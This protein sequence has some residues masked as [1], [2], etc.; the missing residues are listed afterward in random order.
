[1]R[2]GDLEVLIITSRKGS[3]WVLPKGIV[4]PGMTAA[5]S[6]AKEAMEEAGVEGRIVAQSLG[7][8][9]YRKWGGT[10]EVEVFPMEVTTQRKKWPEST[11]RRREWVSLEEAAKRLDPDQLRKLL[12]RLPDALEEDAG[13]G[14]A[15]SAL[16]KPP[17]VVYLLRHAKSSWEDPLLADVDRPLAPRGRRACETM[18]RYMRFADVRPDVVLCSPSVRTR[19]TIE[20]LLPEL[21]GEVPVAYEEALYH[22]GADDLMDRLRRVPDKFNSVLIVGHNPALQALA[23]SLAGAGAVDAMARLR[24]KFPTAGLATLVLREDHWRDLAADACELHSF[25]VP[26]ELA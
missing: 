1:M 2:G 22:G 12:R 19:Q 10:C 9:R 8:Y 21:D 24:A 3:R 15:S 16:A 18:G 17:R 13:A 4:E 20:K 7:N 14:P 26:R 5:A 23:V 25:V 11:F 6:A